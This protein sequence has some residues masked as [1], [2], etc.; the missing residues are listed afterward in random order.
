M[1]KINLILT[2]VIIL[3]CL[4]ACSQTTVEDKLPD[5]KV[6]VTGAVTYQ[7]TNSDCSDLKTVEREILLKSKKGEETNK[8]KG[9]LLKDVLTKAG[10]KEFKSIKVEASDGY[11]K[12]YTSDLVDEN[13]IFAFFKDG[14]ALGEDG[15]VE[16]VIDGQSGNV[17]VKNV[18]KITV[19]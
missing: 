11:S 5:F 2:A 7:I 16:V 12:E 14:K 17:W 4:T 18:S 9:V 10:V 13:A 8:W 1:K 6:E 3:F 15:P 19:D